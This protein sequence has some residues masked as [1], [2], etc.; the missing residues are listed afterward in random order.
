[1]QK[2]SLIQ[3]NPNLRSPEQYRK[4]LLVNVSSSPAIETGASVASIAKS[5]APLKTPQHSAR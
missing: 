1:M 2:K 4:A 3:S 5:L